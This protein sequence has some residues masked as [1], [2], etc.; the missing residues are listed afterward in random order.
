MLFRSG[1]TIDYPKLTHGDIISS[2]NKT[3]LWLCNDLRLKN[4]IEKENRF[5]KKELG[6]FCEQYGFEPW[7][8][9]SRKRTKEKKDADRYKNNNRRYHKGRT[10]DKKEE[11]KRKKRDRYKE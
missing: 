3:G 4:Q 8:S 5:A 7:I 1:G 6:T 11:S 2:I 9:P 10:K